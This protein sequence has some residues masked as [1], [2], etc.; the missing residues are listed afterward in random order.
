MPATLRTFSP[1]STSDRRKLPCLSSHLFLLFLL[2]LLLLHLHLPLLFFNFHV[3]VAVRCSL[4]LFF[5]LRIPLLLSL[6]PLLSRSILFFFSPLYH[7]R[8]DF[9]YNNLCTLS[10]SLSFYLFRSLSGS[11]AACFGSSPI[12]SSDQTSRHGV[13]EGE[14]GGGEKV[15][16]AG[17]ARHGRSSSRPCTES[18][19]HVIK[20]VS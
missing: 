18:L 2:L 16:T 9:H 17:R 6:C 4:L 15:N 11:F 13:E 3:H 5:H 20:L 7:T 19:T 1:P 10:L 12:L 8:T 14:G